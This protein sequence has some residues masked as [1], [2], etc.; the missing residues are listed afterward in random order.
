MCLDKCTLNETDRLEKMQLE[1]A[2]SVS[3]VTRSISLSILY[4]E[5]GWCTLDDRRSYQKLVL[6]CICECVYYKNK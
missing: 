3:C 4:T 5:I 6:I 1:S 2:R